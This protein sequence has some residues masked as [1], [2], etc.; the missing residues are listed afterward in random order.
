M[1]GIADM[2]DLGAVWAV[3]GIIG[4]HSTRPVQASGEPGPT[5]LAR[6]VELLR[7]GEEPV[8][9]VCFGD[10][11]TGVYYHTGGRRAWCDML[12]LVLRQTY[13]R[14]KMDLRNAGV[15]GNTTAAGL[16]RLERDVLAHQP[17][18]VVIMFGMNDCKGAASS[19]LFRDNL[20]TIVQRCRGAGAA[21]VLCTPNSIYPD[22]K[23][24]FA[25]LPSCADA[26]RALAAEMSVPLAD[27]Y[28]AY[29]NLRA[30]DPT[31][32]SLLMSETIH[33]CL[34]GHRLFAETIAA[35]I[36]GRQTV[37]N[38][39]PPPAPA[40]AFTFD[41]LGRNQP[42][43]LIAVPP[44]DAIVPEALR[45]ACPGAV[46]DVTSWPVGALADMEQWGKGIRA[47][48]KKPTLVVVA[49]PANATAATAEGFIRSYNW[50]LN[51]SVAF[52]AATWDTVAVLPSVTER[53]LS[54]DEARFADLARR[55]IVGK[56]IGLIE[57]P[58]GDRSDASAI[59]RR[60]IE[61]QR[62][63]PAGDPLG[64]TERHGEGL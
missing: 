61:A 15:S 10:S 47:R 12:G 26:A 49:V 16:A 18:L 59:V 63:C 17:H 51:W 45:T 8:R 53:A 39:G 42:I 37:L 11:I 35:T 48:A 38:D 19:G 25:N 40:L 60:W 4:T 55:V 44:Y 41:A 29:E 43:H 57:C 5:D 22:D 50:V 33:P 46:V 56:D 21:V 23:E 64:H 52:G 13:P 28:L 1:A 54:R 14:A 31:A 3:F 34:N 2:L 62:R 32:W 30:A 36:S 24:R 7:S 6:V 27:C 9:I 20:K 58:A